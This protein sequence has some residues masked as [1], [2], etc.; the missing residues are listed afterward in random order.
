LNSRLRHR[1]FVLA[2]RSRKVTDNKE[3]SPAQR[4]Q[5]TQRRW[6]V[7]AALPRLAQSM[8]DSRKGKTVRLFQCQC[9]ESI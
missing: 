4:T 6:S 2:G 3:Q 8:L 7:C 5:G 1:M 9:G